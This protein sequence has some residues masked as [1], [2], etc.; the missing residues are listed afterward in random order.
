M[1]N[2][3][4][5]RRI[6]VKEAIKKKLLD[7]AEMY[8]GCAVTFTLMEWVKEN[9]E[10]LLTD[11]PLTLETH[12]DIE[13]DHEEK[14]RPFLAHN[15]FRHSFNSIHPSSFN[16]L[17]EVEDLQFFL[18]YVMNSYSKTHWIPKIPLNLL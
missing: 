7:E 15:L 14:V 12:V 6:N 17:N 10:L 16:K 5:Q 3:S 1:L 18:N 8:L 4:T 9:L 2:F 13:S 11:Q